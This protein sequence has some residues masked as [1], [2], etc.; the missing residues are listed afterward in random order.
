MHFLGFSLDKN[1]ELEI[2]K[3]YFD[4]YRKIQKFSSCGITLPKFLESQLC[5]FF[6]FTVFSLLFIPF[7]IILRFLFNCASFM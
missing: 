2:Q 1:G 3:N 5:P 6:W 7:A 4:F